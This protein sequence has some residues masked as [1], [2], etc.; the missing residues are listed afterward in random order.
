MSLTKVTFSMISGAVANILDFGADPTGSADSTAA[1]QAAINSFATGQ[2]TVRFPRGSYLVTST[3]IVNQSGI[4]LVGDGMRVSRIVFAPTAADTCV[5]IG[6]G[7]EGTTDG[8]IISECSVNNLWFYSDDTTYKKIAVEFK[9]Q[10]ECEFSNVK[11]GPIG[12]WSGAGS[13]GLRTRG[14][15]MFWVK[16]CSITADIPI[17]IGFN[18]NAPTLCAD[19]FTFKNLLLSSA[20]NQPNIQIDD[21][22]VL[23]N[24]VFDTVSMNNG[25]YGIYWNNTTGGIAQS[26]SLSLLNCRYEQ[27]NDPTKYAFYINPPGLIGFQ[28]TSCIFGGANAYPVNGLFLRNCGSACLQTCNV[29]V[30][31]GRE[32]INAN[33]TVARLELVN[34][35][36][37]TGGISAITGMTLVRAD[38]NTVSSG[39]PETGL[40][41]TTTAINYTLNA[42]LTSPTIDLDNGA[43]HV[44]PSFVGYIFIAT[45]DDASATFVLSGATNSTAETSDPS[46]VF[47]I[48]KGT[49]ASYNVYYD[50]GNARYEIEN[51]RGSAK[52]IR[53]TFLGTNAGF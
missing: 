38:K 16:E 9:D 44:V 37:Q 31:G 51:N 12:N 49:A 6:K 32:L 27:S 25:T 39:L 1:I 48:T 30:V 33:S 13:I 42:A 40:F 43:V 29:D 45:N 22:V 50:V 52:K 35:F 15:Q 36:M 28:M 47:S 11:V 5:F 26:T 8:G 34:N 23:F 10:G 17:N 4:N 18:D 7:G 20:A 53:L 3:L 19:F 2:G 41:L 14:R 24:T 21:K 46:G